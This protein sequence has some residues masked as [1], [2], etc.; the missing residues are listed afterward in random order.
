MKVAMHQPD[1]LPY[2]GF[3]YKILKADAFDFAIFDQF[4]KNGYQ[5]RVKFND[6]WVNVQIVDRTK[7]PMKIKIFQVKMKPKETFENIFKAMELE[8]RKTPH[9]AEVRKSLE[10]CAKQFEGVEQMSLADFN[11]AMTVWALGYMKVLDPEKLRISIPPTKPKALGIIE[12][13]K[14]CYEGFDTYLS[15]TGGAAYTTNEFEEAGL[16]CEYSKHKAKYSDSIVGVL[17]RE[18]DPVAVVMAE[19]GV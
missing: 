15:G 4:E 17:C 12:V 11:M 13:M 19:N 2:S 6:R 5:R 16:K 7:L 14:E 1:F 8:Y 3:F 10:E 18:D 9:Y